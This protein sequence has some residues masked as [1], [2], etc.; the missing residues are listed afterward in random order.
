MLKSR[1]AARSQLLRAAGVSPWTASTSASI[2]E[3][4]SDTHTPTS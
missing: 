1:M 4:A 2:V 3:S